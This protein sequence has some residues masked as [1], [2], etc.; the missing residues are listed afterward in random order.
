[1]AIATS[2][3]ASTAAIAQGAPW[4]ATVATNVLG[5]GIGLATG[6]IGN[7]VG[8]LAGGSLGA[9]LGGA[10]GGVYSGVFQTGVSGGDLGRNILSG[11]T[12]GAL[13][14][15]FSLSAA[16]DRGLSQA[17]EAL[18]EHTTLSEYSAMQG[19]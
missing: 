19:T 1:F 5:L 7:G 17:D 8:A 4:A 12:F 9:L 14:A 18:Q 16:S 13:G 10:V 6:G 15:V 2:V 3:M 11:A